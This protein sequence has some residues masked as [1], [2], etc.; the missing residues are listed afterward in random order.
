MIL[1]VFIHRRWHH[2]ASWAETERLIT[3]VVENLPDP[4]PPPVPEPVPKHLAA[5]LLEVL[6]SLPK[7][8]WPYGGTAAE[9]TFTDRHRDPAE[10]WN[11]DSYLHVAVNART[12]YGALKWML[13][14]EST[15]LADPH[16]ADHVWLSDNPAPPAVDPDVLA[17][18]CFP[19]FHHPRS[20]LPATLIRAAVEEFCRTGTG[21][22]PT[23]IDWTPGYLSGQRLDTPE[24]E[25]HLSQYED[26]SDE[27]P[28]LGQLHHPDR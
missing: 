1:S 16:I 21:Q 18:P 14:K 24:P 4:E 25:E 9:F 2:P 11:H 26:I 17:D 13:P 12:R 27:P 8:D 10:E 5:S 7:A 20:A 3:E 6:E 22:R 23:C 15:V 19:R 28:D